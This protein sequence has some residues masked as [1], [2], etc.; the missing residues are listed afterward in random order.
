MLQCTNTTFLI[1]IIVCPKYRFTS[2]ALSRLLADLLD[3]VHLLQLR[4]KRQSSY[5]IRYAYLVLG[6]LSRLVV[7]DGVTGR[8]LIDEIGT[9]TTEGWFTY[10]I[11]G[12]DDV[13][14]DTGGVCDVLLRT[15]REVRSGG[16]PGIL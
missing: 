9:L 11:V 10:P 14:N 13:L 8:L 7:L 6:G 3:Q 12:L 2:S 5:S 16:T 15:Y 4:S 1:H